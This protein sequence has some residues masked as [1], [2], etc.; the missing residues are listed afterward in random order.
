[1]GDAHYKDELPHG[2]FREITD[3][4]DQDL[5][6]WKGHVG[7]LCPRGGRQANY[8][9]TPTLLHPPPLDEIM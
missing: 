6:V 8:G 4:S 5:V 1:M 7:G 9:T 3:Q 2:A